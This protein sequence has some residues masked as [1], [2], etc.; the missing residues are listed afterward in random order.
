MKIKTA[1]TIELKWDSNVRKSVLES[2]LIPVIEN[3]GISEFANKALEIQKEYIPKKGDKLFFLPGCTIP[4]FKMKK[5]CEQY[6]TA[7]VKY[8]TSATALFIGADSLQ[9]LIRSAP[10]YTI[11]KSTVLPYFERFDHEIAERIK[12]TDSDKVYMSGENVVNALR[13]LYNQAPSWSPTYDYN[14]I[15]FNNLHALDTFVNIRD[16]ENIYNQADIARKL[17]S[18]AEMTKEQYES[19]QR[20]LESTDTSNHKVAVEIMSNCDFERSA[21]FLLLL[22]SKHGETIHYCPTSGHVNFKSLK[23]FFNIKY[24]SALQFP[25]VVQILLDKKLMNQEN[26]DLLLPLVTEN[27]KNTV[28]INHFIPS[29]FTYSDEIYKGLEENILDKDNDTIIVPEETEVLNPRI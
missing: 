1:F 7:M 22:I 12:S 26:L 10:S 27:I 8:Q 18:G 25:G 3:M 14:A 11:S 21:G 13:D 20:L 17:N 6:G 24:T 23:K 16:S 19:I 28:G 2:K 4:R 29:S 9:E 15:M 5:F